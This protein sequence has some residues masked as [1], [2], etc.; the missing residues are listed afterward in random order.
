MPDVPNSRQ[1]LWRAVID[2]AL[3]DATARGKSAQNE[4]DRRQARTWLLRPSADFAEVCALADLEPDYVRRVAATRI[5]EYDNRIA[6]IGKIKAAHKARTPTVRIEFDGLNLTLAEWS[7]RTGISVSTLYNRMYYGWEAERILSQP[8][9]V[10]WAWR[11][12]NKLT[13][14]GTPPRLQPAE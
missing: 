5:E 8:A 7:E 6:R 9:T 10:G 11:N 14:K 2:R 1:A 3:E 4:V 13:F 12:T